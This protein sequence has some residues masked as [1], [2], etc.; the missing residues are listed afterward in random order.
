MSII[1]YFK[2]IFPPEPS[3]RTI[4]ANE[5]EAKDQLG[6]E[7]VDADKKEKLLNPKYID[8][9]IDQIKFLTRALFVIYILDSDNPYRTNNTPNYQQEYTAEQIRTI[10]SNNNQLAI[11]IG[12]ML[13]N[14]SDPDED[15]LITQT[16]IM[17]G[18]NPLDSDTDNDG[19]K[20]SINCIDFPFAP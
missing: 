18:T 2:P 7:K 4:P 16:E 1:N 17:I 10:L 20:D 9:A 6:T 11:Q 15:G 8:F 14:S 19:N 13:E 12:R 5:P 3:L